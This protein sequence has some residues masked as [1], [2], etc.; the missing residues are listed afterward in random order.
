MISKLLG[1]TQGTKAS[2]YKHFSSRPQHA[3]INIIGSAKNMYVWEG[4][5]HLAVYLSI[6]V[7]WT[8]TIA[9]N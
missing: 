3:Q 1:E 9:K 8:Y 4:V 6:F 5:V 2:S 7:C